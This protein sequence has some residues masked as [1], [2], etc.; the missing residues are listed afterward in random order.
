MFTGDIG[1]GKTETAIRCGLEA[2]KRGMTFFYVKDSDTFNDVLKLSEKYGDCVIFMEDIDT[3]TDDDERTDDLNEWLNLIDGI[4]LKGRNGLRVIFTTNH[5]EKIN[6][7]ARRPGRIDLIHWFGNLD[8]IAKTHV[9]AFHLCEIPGFHNLDLP[10][11]AESVGEMSGSAFTELCKR[12]A[13]FG[14]KNGQMT[15]N[16]FNDAFGTMKFHLE[17]VSGNNKSEPTVTFD[18]AIAA[19]LKPI[20]DKLEEIA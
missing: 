9:M 11:L 13:I 20:L 6:R 15:A 16:L 5:P 10:A 19:A 3:L 18:A 7:A 12:A 14:R 4:E 17:F 1:T 2:M 8:T